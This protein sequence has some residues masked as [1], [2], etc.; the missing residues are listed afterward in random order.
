MSDWL[1]ALRLLQGVGEGK[2]HAVALHPTHI[3]TPSPPAFTLLLGAGGL[4]TG[5][6]FSSP[7]LVSLHPTH[8]PSRPPSLFFQVLVDRTQAEPTR[9][10]PQQAAPAI[11]HSMFSQVG[12]RCCTCSSAVAGLLRGHCTAVAQLL[13][14]RCRCGTWVE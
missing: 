14:G 13:R 4:N 8:P 1:P 9:M 6:H 7:P 5:F 12:L 3:L 2:C 11:F 10:M